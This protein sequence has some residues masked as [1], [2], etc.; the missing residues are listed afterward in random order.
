MKLLLLEDDAIL[1]DII[2][3][4]L[5]SNGYDVVVAYDGE[6]AQDLLYKETFDLLLL[7][8]NV[9]GVNGFDLLKDLREHQLLTPAIFITS[10]NDTQDLKEGFDSG[11]DD[12]IKKPFEFDE[13]QLRINNIKR[14]Y[15][16]DNNQTEILKPGILYDFKTSSI[17][18]DGHSNV[19]SKKESKVFEY[20]L[21][22]QE[23]I[24]SIEELIANVW[25]YEDTPTH[26]TVRTYI[27]NFRKILGVACIETIKGVGYRFN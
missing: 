1:N 10:L 11:C 4:S 27:K 12:Y 5:T 9:P 13:L 6:E 26:S 25:A 16:L 24:I 7:D 8:V 20:F 22:N 3:L 2:R 23:R 18:I 19:L 15:K 17:L 21:K 14:L